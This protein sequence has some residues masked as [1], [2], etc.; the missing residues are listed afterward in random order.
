MRNVG[1]R[2]T[3]IR[4]M[5]IEA[6]ARSLDWESRTKIVVVQV[7]DRRRFPLH[8]GPWRCFLANGRQ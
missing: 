8:Q 1:V 4:Q 6:L 2:P 5:E 7:R 3:M